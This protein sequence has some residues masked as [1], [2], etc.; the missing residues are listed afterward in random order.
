MSGACS[1][2][3]KG[4]NAYEILLGNCKGKKRL[5][6]PRCAWRILEWILE[7]QGAVMCT[8]VQRNLRKDGVT[9]RRGRRRKQLLSD[10]KEMFSKQG[11]AES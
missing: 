4:E 11:F 1:T 5:G 6:R 7:K 8:G 2:R 3:G 10:L 9:G